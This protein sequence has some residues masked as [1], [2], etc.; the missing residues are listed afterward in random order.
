M[1]YKDHINIF[2]LEKC[3]KDHRKCTLKIFY[4]YILNADIF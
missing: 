3:N 4:M 2:L 1:E